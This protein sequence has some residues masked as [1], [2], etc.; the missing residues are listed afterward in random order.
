MAVT[1]GWE[2]GPQGRKKSSL[3]LYS[4]PF[5]PP[6]KSQGRLGNV[7][8]VPP[9]KEEVLPPKLSEG[10][11]KLI[12]DPVRLKLQPACW[13]WRK[14][15]SAED[16]GLYLALPPF[17]EYST[18]DLMS[19]LSLQQELY[20]AH[21]L[22]LSTCPHKEMRVGKIVTEVASEIIVCLGVKGARIPLSSEM[23]P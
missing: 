15:S 7:F 3:M 13:V 20:C 4:I 21:Q 16:L 18:A 23:P 17:V 6:R 2:V 19:V 10:F 14:A 22:F 1:K 9:M 11:C 12:P 8:I 5:R